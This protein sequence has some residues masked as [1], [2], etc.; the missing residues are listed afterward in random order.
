MVGL[1]VSG[2][3]FIF[4]RYGSNRF[5]HRYV[6][7][8]SVDVSILT[9]RIFYLNPGLL[10]PTKGLILMRIVCRQTPSQLSLFVHDRLKPGKSDS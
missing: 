7:L 9:G 2:P 8:G 3:V 6:F 1:W 10:H 4:N 5:I